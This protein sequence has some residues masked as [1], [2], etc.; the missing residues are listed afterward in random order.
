M[1]EL[2]SEDE[3]EE[4]RHE[5]E[6][7][8]PKLSVILP[9]YNAEPYLRECLESIRQQTLADIEVLCV[10][11]GSTDNSLA[12]INE[13]VREDGRFV[14]LDKPNG[15]YGHS[16]NY[17][18]K[19]ACG[20]YVSIIEPDDFIDSR[21][22]EDLY[23][24]AY[25]DGKTADVVK[26]SYWLYYD[27][28]DGYPE[29]L[30]TP[31]LAMYMRNT[32]CAFSLEE[33][34]EVFCHHPSIWSAIYRRSFLEENGIRFVEPKGAG[35][36]DNPFLAETLISAS[37]IVWVPKPYY[38]YRQTNTGA[39]SFLKDYRI[40]FDRT[41]EMR[42]ILRKHNVSND[43][44]AAL[45]L[46]EFDYIFSVIGEYGF[47]GRDSEIR[48]LIKES[49]DDMDPKIVDTDPRMRT[50]DI[51][52]YHTFRSADSAVA[53]AQADAQVPENGGQRPAPLLTF[54]MPF[55]N[56]EH[57]ISA[58][59]KS[60]REQAFSD[61][62]LV[63][64]DCGGDDASELEIRR[65]AVDDPRISLFPKSFESVPA[66]LNAVIQTIGSDYFEVVSPDLKMVGTAFSSMMSRVRGCD[67]DVICIDASRRHTIDAMNFTARYEV[68]PL[69]GTDNDS[70]VSQPLALT[71]RSG[72]MLCPSDCE[73]YNGI[74]RTSFVHDAG[75]EFAECEEKG[76]AAFRTR[77]LL[78]AKSMLYAGAYCFEN[79]DD[80]LIYVPFQLDLH[81]EFEQVK[82][83]VTPAVLDLV[84]RCDFDGRGL[85]K[86][87]RDLLLACFMRDLETRRSYEQIIC[88]YENYFERVDGEIGQAVQG[89]D[90]LDTEYFER[91]ELLKNQ[92]LTGFLVNKY[93]ISE[94]DARWLGQEL[95]GLRQS[96][97][98]E[99]GE[100]MKRMARAIL[101]I[102]LI[103]RL[104]ANIAQS[105]R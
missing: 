29:E 61:W 1:H 83:L 100:K 39:S 68:M 59:I 8:M 81:K 28:R 2:T 21:M 97:T 84:N 102:S 75:L 94:R 47:S 93:L 51:R 26:G 65:S 74:Y 35:W 53:P 10:N 64:V 17:G 9:I 34:T 22:Y 95:R 66:G 27:G 33:Y 45:Y 87:Y 89:R 96:A 43:I 79:L 103:G 80:D 41:R 105:R 52:F 6:A 73:R 70:F 5:G 62:S 49:L 99:L 44:W 18:L 57:W 104:R 58:C 37:R 36:A 54:I 78:E 46:R 90:V 19:H 76:D 25:T 14:A 77:A 55:A 85:G 56:D 98:F 42:E 12:V 11:D 50:K 91:Y 60:I 67:V 82:P 32:P 38:Y 30:R 88:F 40:P 31:N 24:F 3:S 48:A 16:L 23:Q 86:Y 92:G 7:G 101:P 72:F 69:T 20:E 71:E 4:T 63:A 15:G 13:F